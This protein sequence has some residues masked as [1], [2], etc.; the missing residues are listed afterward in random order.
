MKRIKNLLF[1]GGKPALRSALS[2]LLFFASLAFLDLS[3]R[4]IYRADN[5]F[6]TAWYIP[7]LF[8]LCWCVILTGAAYVMPRLIRRIFMI[9]ATAV[10]CFFVLCHAVFHSFFGKYMSL[11]SV[12]FAGDGAGFFDWSYFDIPK[13]LILAV[14]ISLC[15]TVL[16]VLILPKRRFKIWRIIAAVAAIAVGITGVNLTKNHFYAEQKNGITWDSTVSLRETYDSFTDTYNCMHMVGLY[17]YSARDIYISSGFETLVLKRT[18]SDTAAE[19]EALAESR[20]GYG[21]NEMTGV[22]KDKNLILIQLEAIDTWMLNE[23]AMPNLSKIQSESI[24][25]TEF[26]SPKYLYG[27]TFNTEYVVN[28][29]YVAPSNTSRI[30]V[31]TEN[32]YP[33]SM[34]HLFTDAGY[35]AESFHRSNGSLYNRADSHTNWGYAK[36]N[37]GYD[38]GFEDF[39]LDTSLMGAYDMIV[40]DEGKFM[41]FIITFSG[42]GPFN[43]D[44]KESKLYY[45]MLK[46]QLPEDA[47]DEYVYAL[48]HAYETDAFI[49][50]LFGRLEAD[51][52]L[53]DTV[54]VFYTDHYNHY[55][56]DSNILTKYKGTS[57][58][59]LM[60]NIPFFI[61][62]KDTEPM[63]VEKPVASYDVL[64]TVANLFGLETRAEYYVGDDAFSDRGGYIMFADGSWYDGETYFNAGAA[65]EATELSKERAEEISHRLNASYNTVKLD[66]FKLYGDKIS[67]N[68]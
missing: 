64:P 20:K 53:D 12:M 17:Q 66:Y 21:E 68:K 15:A 67:D 43:A 57:D 30:S 24:N 47:E 5:T 22:F 52:K 6:G 14:L 37:S 31:F 40:P 27:A 44:T 10:S 36:Y 54:V 58:A 19:I 34:A 42:H 49:G 9:L 18:G 51:G 48:C 61:Y 4:Y 1:G 29:G 46:P 55:V 65:S 45:E 16:A 25:F 41:S 13:K 28:T 7:A 35:R 63:T 39:D 8:T 59:N 50:E 60:C 3:F 38:M 33:Y 62:S 2:S 11:S 23:V 56:S 32:S 26:Y